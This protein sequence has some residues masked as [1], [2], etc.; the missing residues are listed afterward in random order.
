MTSNF[1][2]LFVTLW[3]LHWVRIG[4]RKRMMFCMSGICAWII[5]SVPAYFPHQKLYDS[6]LEFRF[7]HYKFTCRTLGEES[8]CVETVSNIS[9]PVD[10]RNKLGAL[11]RQCPAGT[12]FW[13]LQ[14]LLRDMRPVGCS[15]FVFPK[16]LFH[17]N[18]AATSSEGCLSIVQ[19]VCRFLI[20][21]ALWAY[22][23]G[24]VY[25]VCC[26]SNSQKK[27]KHRN[28]LFFDSGEL[29]VTSLSHSRAS[30]LWV[31]LYTA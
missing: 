5:G 29:A 7:A 17:V 28:A 19:F 20:Y 10:A 15:A 3:D 22:V 13:A 14:K 16:F 2:N 21:C 27:N 25:S 4:Q 6:I 26:F 23:S 31:W 11:N 8:T 1:E 12:S 9:I 18:V 24:H 30:R